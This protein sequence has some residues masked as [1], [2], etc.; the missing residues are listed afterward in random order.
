MYKCHSNKAQFDKEES[1]LSLIPGSTIYESACFLFSDQVKCNLVDA[2]TQKVHYSWSLGLVSVV[3]SNIST[4]PPPPAP[5]TGCWSI[6]GKPQHIHDIFLSRY[7]L[8]S[9]LLVSSYTVDGERLW[10]VNSLNPLSPKSDKH[11][12]SPHNITTWSNSQVM[13]IKEM[14][15]KVNVSWCSTKFSHVVL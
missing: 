1:F 14:I 10:G 12:N 7:Q 8:P 5:Q 3:R 4:P 15:T 6:P 9:G 13:R 2:M 11:L